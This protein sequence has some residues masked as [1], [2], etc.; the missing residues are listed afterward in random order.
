MIICRA[1]LSS[2]MSIIMPFFT[3]PQWEQRYMAASSLYIISEN[4]YENI[5][6]NTQEF[7]NAMR[8]LLHDPCMIVS[9]QAA[10]FFSELFEYLE[11]EVLE[12]CP[13]WIDDVNSVRK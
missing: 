12:N 9:R 4:C 8:P 11:D 3:S 6:E 2:V 7:G 10:Y 1:V 13:W 5:G